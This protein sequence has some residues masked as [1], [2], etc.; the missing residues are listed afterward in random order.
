MALRGV[1]QI[2]HTPFEENGDIDWSSLD[3]QIE[4]CLR[5]GAHGL[6][7]PANASEFYTLSDDERFA[8]VDR[9]AKAIGGAVPLVVGVQ[10][11]AARH[12][13]RFAEH[14][15]KL[16]AAAIMSMPPLIR[17]ATPQ[18][19]SAYYAA[20]GQVGP[21]VIIQN[22]PGPIGS[23]QSSAAL[24]ALIAE[25]ER[26]TYIKEEVSPILHRISAA[27]E[28][29]G[30]ACKG[31]FGGA[32]G[33]VMVEEL[34]RG[35]CGNMPAGGVVDVQV[36]VM[37]AYDAGERDT[38]IELQ[39]RL[40]PLLFHASTHGAVFHKYLLWR[41]GVLD[42]PATRDPQALALDRHDQEVIEDRFTR[43][44]DLVDPQTPLRA[45][46]RI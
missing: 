41:R 44:A 24:A 38:A 3:R 34:D 36:R 29:A 22:A 42:S 12:A 13:V 5:V 18:I 15:E 10:A 27:R 6:V 28:L 37:N 11:G 33:L 23:P 25:N 30:D 35:G 9:S 40:F 4:F 45:D 14:A 2:V 31:V 1:F 39:S 26:V 19:V 20:L 7:M 17:T 43:I 8:V 32:N 46:R 16:G 21:D